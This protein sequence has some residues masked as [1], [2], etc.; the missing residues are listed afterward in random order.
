[1]SERVKIKDQVL[2]FVDQLSQDDLDRAFEKLS[3]EDREML[4]KL[5]LQLIERYVRINAGLN[6]KF[7]F[8][9]KMAFE[10]LAKL[11][12]FLVDK[13]ARADAIYYDEGE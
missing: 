2:F 8:G 5:C 7:R 3:D 11:G 10:L 12:N 4:D 9:T 6:S 1:M 13:K